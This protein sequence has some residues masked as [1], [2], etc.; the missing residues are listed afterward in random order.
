MTG[1]PRP[2]VALSLGRSF[3]SRQESVLAEL[4]EIFLREGFRRLTIQE[5]AAR[6]HC[7][8]RT[9]YDLAPSK[10]ELVAL[11]VDRFL[12]RVG[13]QAMAQAR[14]LEE[15]LGRVHAYMSAA[16]G[17]LTRAARAF[18]V[19]VAGQPGIRRLFQEHY[20]FATSVAAA[21]IQEGIDGG[22]FRETDARLV[23]E[24]IYAALDRLQDPEVL[25]HLGRTNAEAFQELFDLIV[26]GLARPS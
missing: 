23:A 12:Q 3:T 13:R 21:L 6:L 4:E 8:R 20:R 15:P 19:D 10:D 22:A 26:L 5:L 18:S 25:E 24:V 2:P 9:L 16:S 1:Y 17:A 11:V 14:A 7:S